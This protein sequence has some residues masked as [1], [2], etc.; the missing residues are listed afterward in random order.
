MT[1]KEAIDS[2]FE[3]FE[4][5]MVTGEAIINT[6]SSTELE[7]F[8][9]KLQAIDIVGKILLEYAIHDLIEEIDS[10]INE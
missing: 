3:I 10:I 7:E 4:A 5:Y 8:N 2:I 9:E 6:M 1:D